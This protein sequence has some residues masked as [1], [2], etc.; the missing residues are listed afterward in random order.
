MVR[1]IGLIAVVLTALALPSRAIAASFGIYSDNAAAAT[2]AATVVTNQG[3][4][5]VVLA[6]LSGAQIAG[7]DVLWILN[8][9]NSGY[10]ANITSNVG[11]I[12][13][14]VAAGG[15]L[16]FHDRHVD[17][18]NTVLPGAGAIDFVRDVG[19]NNPGSRGIDV[20]G[21]AP[22]LITNGPGGVIDDGTLD[23]GTESNHGYVLQSGLPVGAV[24]VFNTGIADHI[25]DFYY[26]FGAG[27]VYYS[28]IP[29]DYYF[30]GNNP[31]AFTGIYAKNEA[32][33]Q[34][35]LVPEPASLLLLGMG[36]G[37]LGFVARKRRKAQA[38]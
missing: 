20:E 1:R 24:P 37:S 16:S 18:A 27:W 26:A 35:S 21:T 2:A 19:G 3:N 33:F 9:D 23:N 25:V 36:I 32:A 30:S 38:K 29:L 4:I 10:G 17:T 34:A 13:A 22:A 11:D 15:V 31:A 8:A 14:F 12:S 5:A 7:F 28:T 6:G